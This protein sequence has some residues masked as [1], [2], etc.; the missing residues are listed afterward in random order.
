[1]S[2]L[3]LNTWPTVIHWLHYIMV[4]VHW[5]LCL[6]NALTDFLCHGYFLM[7]LWRCSEMCRALLDVLLQLVGIG[8]AVSCCNRCS[9]LQNY[10]IATWFFLVLQM[11]LD[12]C[13]KYVLTWFWVTCI[14]AA[15][16]I[17]L[18]LHGSAGVWCRIGLHLLV[19]PWWTHVTAVC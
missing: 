6:A 19:M 3:V 1:M 4:V 16:L 17:D 5:L 13:F 18:S 15:W 14:D 9:V 10:G 11:R 12:R 8:H 7:N 2:Q